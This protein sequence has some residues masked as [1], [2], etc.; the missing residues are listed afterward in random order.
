MKLI[1]IEDAKWD[2]PKNTYR[3]CVRIARLCDE[4]CN[5]QGCFVYVPGLPGCASQG[6]TIEE[7]LE[8]IREALKGCMES[9]LEHDEVIP[10]VRNEDKSLREDSDDPA[11]EVWELKRH[12]I[13]K[14]GE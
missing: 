3:V 9:Y 10:W 1:R 4:W 7:A 8:N 14:L 5:P 2:Y 13:V 12:V 6:D 11:N